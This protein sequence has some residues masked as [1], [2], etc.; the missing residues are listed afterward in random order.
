MKKWMA[1]LLSCVLAGSMAA[2]RAAPETAPSSQESASKV[3]TPSQSETEGEETSSSQEETN[4]QEESSRVL[5][6]YFSATNTTEQVAERMAQ[7][8]G[9]DLY[10]I[11]PEDPYTEEDLNYNDSGSRASMEQ[12]DPEAR[13]AIA[14]DVYPI[15]SYEVVFLGYPIWWG[16]APKIMATFLERYDWTGKTLVPFCTSGSSGITASVETLQ[17]LAEGAVWQEGR[18]FEGDTSQEEIMAWVEEL[19][20]LDE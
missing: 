13:P 20:V 5:V 16:E 10:E 15:D 11:V 4:T 2:C 3:S 17:P 14:G 9:A 6:V 1:F 8:M 12:N 7:E 19:G 18:R